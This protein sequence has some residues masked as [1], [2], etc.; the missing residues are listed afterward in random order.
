MVYCS[1]CTTPPLLCSSAS[2]VQRPGNTS[3][4]ESFSPGRMTATCASMAVTEAMTF[5]VCTL[6]KRVYYAVICV[7]VRRILWL[8]YSKNGK[9]VRSKLECA[10]VKGDM[11]KS[12]PMQG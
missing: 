5:S 9:H 3:A 11:L 4:H 6:H 8:V 10:C 12:H 7:C 2:R 1:L